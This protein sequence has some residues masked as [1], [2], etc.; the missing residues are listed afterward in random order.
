[1]LIKR[2]VIQGFKTFAK[3]TEFVFDPGVT[4]IVGPNGSG[5]SNIVDAIRWCLG[6]QSF[7]LLRS[8]KTSDIIFSGSDK[9]ARL[10]MAQVSLTLD[11]SQ[12]EIPIDYAEVEIT[13]RA[14][15]DGDNEYLVNG[16]RVRLMDVSELLA[17]TG[18][19]KRTYALIGQGL[20]DKVL[21]LAPEE[22]RALFEEAAGITGYQMKRQTTL[23]R[24]DATQQNLTRVQ[25]I[26]NELS[27]RLKYLKRQADRATEREQIANDL[28]STLR[29]WYG[30]RWHTAL[31]RLEGNHGNEE[32]LKQTVVK[33]QEALGKVGEL[34]EQLRTQQTDLRTA[35][36]DLHSR[37]SAVHRE[38]EVTGRELAVVQERTRQLQDRLEETQRELGPLRLQKE[39]VEA[40]IGDL[41]STLTNVEAETHQRQSDVSNVELQVAQ[42]AQERQQ[43][44]AALDGA[45]RRLNELLRDHAES[46]SRLE[47][48]RER[49]TRLHGEQAE[50]QAAL[51]SAGQQIEQLTTQLTQIQARVETR[52]ADGERLTDE[53]ARL[54]AA[55]AEER[56]LLQAAEETRQQADRATDRLQ[57]RHDLL[58]RLQNEGAG[59]ASGVRVV[60]QKNN[61]LNGVIGTVASLIRVPAHLD[62]AVE[63]ALGGALQNVVVERWQDATKAIDFLKRT[64]NGRVTFLPL[65]RLNVLPAIAAPKDAGILGNGAELV[66]YDAQVTDVAMQLLGRV[67]IADDLPAAR[68][69]LDNLR[70]GARPTVVT[71]A[72]EI[73][74]PG[75]AVTGGSDRSRSDESILSRER[76][77][78]EL[79]G[80]LANAQRQADAAAHHCRQLSVRIEDVQLQIGR[81]QELVADLAN[82]ERQQQ[83]ELEAARLQLNRAQQAAQF[84]QDRLTQIEQELQQSTEQEQRLSSR[85][86]DLAQDQIEAE[87]AL[88]GAE[89]ELER[90]GA[91]DLL[92]ELADLRAAAAEAQGNLRSQRTLHENQYRLL[93]S[94][95]DQIRAKEQRINGL[96]TEL[97]QLATQTDTLN[98]QEGTLGRQIAELARE[99]EPAEKQLSQLESRQAEAESQER[100]LQT[101]LRQDETGWNNAQLQRQRTEDA[102]QQLR[103]EIEQDLGLVTLEES[104]DM[105]YQPPLPLETFV[106]QL[107]L[108]T[109]LPEGL[110]AEVKEMRVRLSR[111]SNVNP[112]AP[113]EYEEASTRY[114]F[115]FTQS[116]DLEAAAGDLRKVIKELDELMEVELQRTFKAVAEQFEHFFKV[117]FNGGTAKLVL[118]E[119]DDMTNTG[120]EIIARPPG[121]RPQSLALL[122][123]GERTLSACALIFAILRVSPTPFCVLDE[124]DAALDEANVDRFR[125]TLEELSTETQFIIVT[126]NRRT[127]EG[128]NTIYGITMGNDGI[129]RVISLRL[130]GNKMVQHGAPDDGEEGDS[131]DLAK[132]E[133]IVQ[134]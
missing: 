31:S 95:T 52:Q 48:L 79:P 91:G 116:N 114:D 58:Q 44:Q 123:G 76:E 53:I 107:P 113:R 110:D 89:R 56:T 66:D 90:A 105:A 125:L 83:Q 100:N 75:G 122:S 45:R 124:V 99:I 32:L 82:L 127:L 39:T 17:Q 57:T 47:Q 51:Q 88:S 120:I 60:L 10:G 38:A 103:Y 80:E 37:S 16:Q 84:Q 70:G 34:I 12:G 20:I 130:E 7:S 59:Y 92:R 69:A 96:Q 132:I 115:L 64:G 35:L 86:T 106:E 30:F 40:R 94:V 46:T 50:Q 33:R 11:N 24:L 129:S 6:E 28:R 111:V 65:D 71:L 1:M 108:V 119:P 104:D 36:G 121:K 112:E 54:S 49:R 3:K 63:T 81:Q 2:V 77:L 98:G 61:E 15:R 23:R 22:R 43:L 4:A 101:L 42:R 109:E 19:G 74:R 18:L 14:Y 55:V 27:P 9:K 87:Q 8:K 68:R 13:R 73:V 128:A 62:K 85:L 29:I 78:R 21:R 133:E 126:H 131:D 118:T 5:K 25:D 134:M 97:A 117:L 72:G 26:I 93:Q 102:I 41:S 67:W